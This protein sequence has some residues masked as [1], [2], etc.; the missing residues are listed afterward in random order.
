MLNIPSNFLLNDDSPFPDDNLALQEL[1]GLIAIGKDLSTKR[2][3]QAYA[4]GIFPWHMKGD[5]I[6]WYSPD[7]RMII[8]KD[9]FHVSKNLSK[10][11][12]RNTFKV[13]KNKNFAKVIKMC[14]DIKRKDENTSWINDCFISAYCDLNK[15][16]YSHSYEVYDK[17]DALVGGLYGVALGRVFF[18]ESMFSLVSNTAKV[19]LYHLINSDD[20]DLIDCQVQN[21]HLKS[22][23]GFNISRDL[24][25]KKIKTFM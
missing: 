9:S 4:R 23:G 3:L 8:S 6:F 12:K 13:K 15:K 1:N 11:I 17:N 20:Y 21:D 16:G 2:L 22:L 10:L 5:Y 24:F 25:V 14:K 18:G 19:A 7:P